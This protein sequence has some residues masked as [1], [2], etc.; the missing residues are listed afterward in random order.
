M[1]IQ[2]KSLFYNALILTASGIGL[3]LL[4]FGYRVFLS[5]RIGADGMGVFALVM[6][7]YSV[8]LAITLSGVG[9]AVT[10]VASERNAL[11]DHAGT[12]AVVGAAAALFFGLFAVAAALVL[13]FSGWI[14]ETLLGDAETQTALLLLLP[15]LAL[16]GMEN[17]VKSFFYG[18]QNVRSPALSDQL[19]QIVRI[20]AVAALLLLLPAKSSAEAAALIVGGMIISELFSSTFLAGLYRRWRRIQGV[21]PVA[22]AGRGLLGRLLAMAL[23]V[24]AAALVNNLLSSANTV[25]IP[26]RL[27]AAGYTQTAAISALGVM[28]GMALPLYMIPMAFVSPIATLMLPKL[29][30]STALRDTADVRRKVGRSMQ[31]TGLIALPVIAVITPLGPPICQ[32]I[33]GQ[34]VPAEHFWWLAGGSAL[35]YYQI[36]TT[37]LLN[38]VGLQN[39]A[40]AHNVLGGVVQL[41]FTWFAV[42][43]SRLGLVGFLMGYA[44]DALIVFTL[45]LQ[46][47][48]RALDLRVEWAGWFVL[49]ALSA[50]VTGFAT[51]NVH[52]M[53]GASVS[54]M[55]S[56]LISIGTG[57]TFFLLTLRLQGVDAAG[58]VRAQMGR[59]PGAIKGAPESIR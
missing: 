1:K 13:G 59:R 48:H 5:W 2:R 55:H 12:G 29:T 50:L 18:V 36:I 15:C 42:A 30:E 52:H 20:V 33:Y 39:R 11:K 40:M 17:I 4:G 19:E 45:N 23:P 6:P 8:M 3:Q 21:K 49:P 46:A 24:A 44:A 35:V 14:S 43:D 38:G 47:L 57:L 26:Q 53:L 56:L 16:T 7:A 32:L 51:G 9:T 31:V 28:M 34:N 25:L 37:S 58:Y 54:T 22:G 10:A 27:M 41:A